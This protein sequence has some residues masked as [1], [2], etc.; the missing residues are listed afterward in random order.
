M[1]AAKEATAKAVLPYA[2]NVLLATEDGEYGETECREAE[3][4]YN[5]GPVDDGDD[6]ESE[7]GEDIEPEE[8][9]TDGEL[10]IHARG[11]GG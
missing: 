6:G 2:E 3:V 7:A 10:Q 8:H 5:G 1:F 11:A 9:D 4:G